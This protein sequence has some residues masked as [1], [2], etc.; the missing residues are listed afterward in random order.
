MAFEVGSIFARLGLDT[1]DFQKGVQRAVKQAESLRQTASARLKTIGQSL[2]LDTGRFEK[3]VTKVRRFIKAIAGDAD[4]NFREIQLSRVGL[5]R[6]AVERSFSALGDS[7]QNFRAVASK[8]L[9]VLATD[10]RR[11]F[12]Q[13]DFA[14]ASFFRPF[15]EIAS[16]VGAAVADRIVAPLGRAFTKTGIPAFAKALGQFGLKAASAG[17]SIAQKVFVRFP[18]EALRTSFDIGRNLFGA[19]LEQG[20]ELFVRFPLE[21]AKAIGTRLQAAGSKLGEVLFTPLARAALSFGKVVGDKFIQP[22]AGVIRRN[23][24]GPVQS[25]FSSVAGIV[26]RKFRLPVQAGFAALKQAG[27]IAISSFEPLKRLAAPAFDVAT[28]AVDFSLRLFGRTNLRSLGTLDLALRATSGTVR[29]LAG[30]ISRLA[31]IGVGTFN[32][33]RTGVNGL[34]APLRLL[35]GFFFSLKGILVGFG[36]IKL[37]QRANEVDNLSRG[38]EGLTRQAGIL[39]QTFLGKLRRA[40]AGVVSD[41]D[42]L[43]L[44]N[45]ALLLDIVKSEDQFAE[46]AEGARRLGDATGVNAARAIEILT[47]SIAGQNS[48]GLKNLG[49]IVNTTE[50][51]NAYAIAI[52]KSVEAFT[53]ADQ[54]QAFLAETTRKLRK[55][56]LGLG[57]DVDTVS[58][59]WGRLGASVS[60]AFT[61]ISVQLVGGRIPNAISAFI[62]Q[63]IRR[64]EV[65]TRLIADLG[66]A[67]IDAL[68]R[69]ADEFFRGDF[70]SKFEKINDFIAQAVGNTVQVALEVVAR[71]LQ[72]AF[73]AL[74]GIAIPLA[75]DFTNNVIS[76]IISTI[77]RSFPRII[78][79]IAQFLASGPLSTLRL[80]PGSDFFIPS[81]QSVREA[82]D[83]V[84]G[85]VQPFADKFAD[86]IDEA[87]KAISG[88]VV[89]PI[90]RKQ[91][92]ELGEDLQL[93]FDSVAK[94]GS[95]KLR[96]L[97]ATAGD[98]ADSFLGRLKKGFAAF[99][100]N[101]RNPLFGFKVPNVDAALQS[102]AKGLGIAVDKIQELQ[103]NFPNT[104]GNPLAVKLAAGAVNFFTGAVEGASKAVVFFRR[105]LGQKIVSP[106][107]L[108]AALKPAKDFVAQARSTL[109]LGVEGQAGAGTSA[110]I[111]F[112]T[113]GLEESDRQIQLLRDGLDRLFEV[114]TDEEARKQIEK[115]RKELEEFS[116]LDRA[117]RKVAEFADQLKALQD[118]VRKFGLTETQ[119]LVSDIDV[120]IDRVRNA[121]G[122]SDQERQ[123]AL[124]QLSKQ[125]AEASLAGGQLA[126]RTIFKETSDAV[127]TGL[128]DGF[129]RGEKPS[130]T[131]AN[132]L[133]QILDNALSKTINNLGNLLTS[134]LGKIF[135]KAQFGE[136]AVN[137][138]T[139]IVAVAGLAL[140]NLKSRKD[141]T[142]DDFSEAID[143]T[144][145][146]RGVVAG[147]TNVA[148]AKVGE[149]LKQALRTT[150]LLLLRIAVGVESGS[151]GQPARASQGPSGSAFRLSTSTPS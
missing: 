69:L 33:L 28:K 63:N 34:L 110:Q 142:V 106:E 70:V 91:I 98:D 80:L 90:V 123:A 129:R 107:D 6:K 131:W 138:L 12:R 50:A 77:I 9:G 84:I 128:A 95:S 40:T 116:A 59:A 3:Q 127:F 145:A 29:G 39:S 125:R 22:F 133:S 122:I 76:K 108:N 113:L 27:K 79:E 53:E 17:A 104:F 75:I 54:R 18:V 26:D 146:V 25:A 130:K 85:V 121:T 55:A 126:S 78:S 149:G 134:V 118:Q 114:A 4:K 141:A 61:A 136:G 15:R 71:A 119:G 13:L 150:E 51:Q 65:F 115:V 148:I 47:E 52:N 60:N 135:D 117:G 89:Q 41:L 111:K 137:A 120:E 21:A 35:S 87:N 8:E 19:A 143:S 30:F 37:I 46:L 49:L 94:D 23:I 11:I 112:E 101:L 48:R 83:S 147:P 105:L 86:K 81:E 88:L 92:K 36:A 97:F 132:I 7:F 73:R 68:G 56:V 93:V 1:S 57:P 58:D 44:G 42:L 74:A 139:G 67:A 103:K 14:A 24:I 100:F 62:D 144:E 43:R 99:G 64:L 72:P 66:N 31:P 20:R 109:G 10:F 124:S 5:S 140:S 45:S 82:F 151:L 2:G 38:F 32:A 102:L 16:D 96:E